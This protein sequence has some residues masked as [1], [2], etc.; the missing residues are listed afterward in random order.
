MSTTAAGVLLAAGAGTRFGMPKVLA[1]QGEWLRAG[2]EALRD[3]GC[4]D[5]VVVLGAAV[6]DVPGAARAVIADNWS[7]RVVARRCVRA[8]ALLTPISRSCTPSTPRM[9]AP[10]RCAECWRRRARPSGLARA[11]YAT[12]PGHPRGVGAQALAG[13]LDGLRGDEGAR[14]VPVGD[15]PMWSAWIAR[16]WP[17]AATSTSAVNERCQPSTAE[18]NR[19]TDSLGDRARR[20]CGR[21]AR[22]CAASR[23]SGRRGPRPASHRSS[24]RT[25]PTS[26]RSSAAHWARS[27]RCSRA[28]V[29]PIAASARAVVD[30]FVLPR[31]TQI[32]SA[33]IDFHGLHVLMV[34]MGHE[35]NRCY[36]CQRSD[37]HQSC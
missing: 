5:V 9:S 27:G 1:A 8:F 31:R 19:R 10:T 14:S 24:A 29:S 33:C 22:G 35:E 2:V 30:Q 17:P 12:T 23:R 32:P 11:T 15:V 37:R 7:D 25:P 28:S 4:D 3:G 16:T 36:R 21:R 34:G 18:A 13:L 26:T 6:V 20:R